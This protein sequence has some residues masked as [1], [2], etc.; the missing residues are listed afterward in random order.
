MVIKKMERRRQKKKKKIP[1][2]SRQDG[3][4][5]R[6]G[7]RSIEKWRRSEKLCGSQFGIRYAICL[8]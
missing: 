1:K 7:K 6:R 4:L 8:L 2:L 3:N 5:K